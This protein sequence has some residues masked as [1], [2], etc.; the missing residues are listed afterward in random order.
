MPADSSPSARRPAVNHKKRAF[1][2]AANRDY[3][4]TRHPLDVR[5]YIKGFGFSLFLKYFSLPIQSISVLLTLPFLEN[6]KTGSGIIYRTVTFVSVISYSMY[7]LCF[8][9]FQ[10]IHSK[11]SSFFHV[12]S[13]GFTAILYVAITFGGAYFLNRLIEKPFMN[14]RDGYVRKKQQPTAKKSVPT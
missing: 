7:L 4:R 1:Q 9:P 2:L 6:I 10:I 11:L 8:T 14:L 13:I 5:S 3:F 12:N